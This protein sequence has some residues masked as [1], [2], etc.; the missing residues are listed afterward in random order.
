MGK[1]K[2]KNF[3]AGNKTPANFLVTHLQQVTLPPGL[4]SPNLPTDGEIFDNKPLTRYHAR[5]LL[6]ALS[7]VRWRVRAC[8][9][10][11]GCWI[12]PLV[13]PATDK[14]PQLLFLRSTTVFFFLFCV[15]LP[16][17]SRVSRFFCYLLEI[18]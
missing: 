18:Q 1:I 14:A 17:F 6:L 3:I 13:S 8:G 9:A 5:L 11:S 15:R 16:L 12:S 2:R 7:F 4:P 10:H